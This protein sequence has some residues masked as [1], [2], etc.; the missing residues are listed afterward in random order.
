MHPECHFKHVQKV[1]EC[2]DIVYTLILFCGVAW[3]PVGFTFLLKLCSVLLPQVHLPA[4][5]LP[6]SLQFTPQHANAQLHALSLLLL[7]RP[8]QERNQRKGK[9][10]NI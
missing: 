10:E 7:L 8:K 4:E 2:A 6:L 9:E 3:A 1:R 5:G